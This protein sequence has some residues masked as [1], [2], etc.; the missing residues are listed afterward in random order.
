VTLVIVEPPAPLLPT[1][2]VVVPAPPAPDDDEL[3]PTV[4]LPVLPLPVL[5]LPVLPLPVLP[6]PLPLLVVSLPDDEEAPPEPSSKT[7]TSC[8]QAN[9]TGPVIKVMPAAR[10]K[11]PR[12][13]ES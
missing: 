11:R 6:L 7:V 5:S 10:S 1:D 8:V 13:M 12:K 3:W 2:T 9:S 4:T